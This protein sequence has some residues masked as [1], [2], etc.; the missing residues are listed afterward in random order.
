LEYIDSDLEREEA[1]K[2]RLKNLP[3]WTYWRS[4]GGYDKTAKIRAKKEAKLLRKLMR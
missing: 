1:E 2:L 3:P 4:V